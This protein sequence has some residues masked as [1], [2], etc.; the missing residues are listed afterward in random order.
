[1]KRATAEQTNHAHTSL[2][3]LNP[4][5]KQK[6]Q[7]AMPGYAGDSRRARTSIKADENPQ[8]NEKFSILVADQSD[9]VW[10]T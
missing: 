6:A 3:A 8:W 4:D 7:H 5:G 10:L 9:L 1:M 2:E